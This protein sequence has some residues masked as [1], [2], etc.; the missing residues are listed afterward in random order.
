MY[1]VHS[2]RI[3][4]Q[5]ICIQYKN[6]LTMVLSKNNKIQAII[7]NIG[8]KS[9][10]VESFKGHQSTT[11]IQVHVDKQDH[12]CYQPNMMFEVVYLTSTCCKL[13]LGRHFPFWLVSVFLVQSNLTTVCMYSQYNA[14]D[15]GSYTCDNVSCRAI[16]ALLW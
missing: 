2:N 6:K 12:Y 14:G 16:S 13:P 15:A 5:A 10:H 7:L 8:S 4:I 9:N 3:T 1:S 11:C